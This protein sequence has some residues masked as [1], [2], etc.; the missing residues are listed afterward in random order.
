MISL[1]C[2]LQILCLLSQSEHV[3]SHCMHLHKFCS[4]QIAAR[5]VHFRVSNHIANTSDLHS[6]EFRV[7]QGQME[8]S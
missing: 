4:E 7:I 1:C 2:L 8:Y 3:M 5:Q 6:S